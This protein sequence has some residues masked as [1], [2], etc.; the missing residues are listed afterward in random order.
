MEREDAE[1]ADRREEET[2]LPKDSERLRS[3]VRRYR[4]VHLRERPR[5]CPARLQPSKG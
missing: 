1:K 4:R 2:A 5:F 3:K